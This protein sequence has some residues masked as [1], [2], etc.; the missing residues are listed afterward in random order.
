MF[1]RRVFLASGL[2]LPSLRAAGDDLAW[3]SIDQLQNLLRRKQT[4]P[5]ELTRIC[6]D[7][8][9]NLNGKLNAFVTVTAERALADAKTLESEARAGNWRGPLHGIPVGL[10]DLYD[11]AGVRT[12]ACSKQWADRVPSEDAEAVRRLK[13]AGAIVLGKLNMDEFAYNFTGET[14]SFGTSRNPWDVRRSPGGSSGGSAVAVAAGLCF[15]ALGSDTGGSIRLPAALCGITGFKPTYGTV[16][17]AGV[18]P[19]AWSLDHVGP[20]CRTARDAA[21]MFAALSGKPTREAQIDVGKLRL[22]VPRAIFYDRLEPEVQQAVAAAIKQL[23]ALTSGA[24]D[25]VL[26]KLALS[27]D[28][29]GFLESYLRIISAEAYTFHQQMLR[30]RP[31]GYD[32]STRKNLEDG[33]AIS[34]PEYIRARQEMDRVRAGM[35]AWFKDADLLI[36]PAAPGVAFEFGPR[37]LVFLRNAAYW[38]VF[39]VPAISIPCGYT[40]AGL[41]VGLQIIGP[42]GKD[43]TVLALAEAYQKATNW[44]TRR[45]PVA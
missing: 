34:A 28:V 27:A 17:T 2:A 36:T 23:G 45:P 40:P 41:P 32:P 7:R 35:G 3:T 12:T 6:L 13:N 15:A 42:A 30:D 9:E 43:D 22:G 1:S 39:G 16:S 21:I 10:K 14:S 5:V 29:P 26:P 4:S 8:I 25:V 44:H 33:A 38:N 31:G 20:M 11:T 19:L 18:A 24:R 37:R